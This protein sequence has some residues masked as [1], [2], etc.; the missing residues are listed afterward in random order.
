[1]PNRPRC[2][3]HYVLNAVFMFFCKNPSF[4]NGKSAFS[5][6]LQFFVFFGEVLGWGRF[7]DRR[8]S[9]PASGNVCDLP[10]RIPFASIS[11][12]TSSYEFPN[13]ETHETGHTETVFTKEVNKGIF[14]YRSL[15]HLRRLCASRTVPIFPETNLTLEGPPSRQSP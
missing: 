8:K 6:I 4:L 1:M 12:S 5:K 9:L 3:W 14:L 2:I 10:K 15:T 13:M 11:R 7:R